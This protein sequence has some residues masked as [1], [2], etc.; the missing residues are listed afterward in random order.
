MLSTTLPPA[1]S[2]IST[3]RTQAPSLANLSAMARPIPFAAPVTMATLFFNRSM[4]LCHPVFL[5]RCFVDF[6]SQ[7]RSLRNT[8]DAILEAQRVQAQIAAQR[9]AGHVE[10]LEYRP[11]H[12]R[13]QV[14]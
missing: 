6:H 5:D 14:H 12:E 11:A 13:V 1:S 3:T 9:A 8:Q 4:F 7:T 2:S 10:F